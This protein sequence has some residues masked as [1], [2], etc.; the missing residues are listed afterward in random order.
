METK[1]SLSVN[2]LI[3]LNPQEFNERQEERE[4]EWET[5][6]I[7]MIYDFRCR[8]PFSTDQYGTSFSES[9]PGVILKKSKGDETLTHTIKNKVIASLLQ[10]F[11][12][13]F[14]ITV[15]CRHLNGF[16]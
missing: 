6:S 4:R 7:D 3:N 8:S 13:L 1:G 10:R 14:F 16:G 11:T 12:S 15:G 9:S 2:V 5:I